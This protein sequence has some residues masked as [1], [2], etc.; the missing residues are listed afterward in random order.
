MLTVFV[1]V[2]VGPVDFTEV[3]FEGA[4]HTFAAV[5]IGV[6]FVAVTL[7]VAVATCGVVDLLAVVVLTANVAAVVFEGAE[8]T[9]A[10][11]VIGIDFAVVTVTVAVA[12]DGVVGL[13]TAAV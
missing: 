13:L 12:I 7:T 10:A 9:F 11:V 2:V 4:E 8:E 1:T 5:V 3:V 6:D